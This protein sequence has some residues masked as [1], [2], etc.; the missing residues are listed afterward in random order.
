MLQA[1]SIA[2]PPPRPMLDSGGIREC[3]TNFTEIRNVGGWNEIN[4][5]RS[6]IEWTPAMSR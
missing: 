5:L 3:L 4:K 6:P 1:G 2:L